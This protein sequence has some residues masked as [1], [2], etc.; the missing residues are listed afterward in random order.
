M[1]A[2]LHLL[3]PVEGTIACPFCGGESLTIHTQQG[4]PFV[5]CDKCGASGPPA[6]TV[7]DAVASWHERV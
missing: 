2:D 4:D 5:E 3:E 7:M 6:P 1:N